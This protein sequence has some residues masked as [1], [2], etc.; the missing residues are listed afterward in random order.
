[1]F[2]SGVDADDEI[3]ETLERGADDFLSKPFN[4]SRLVAKVRAT[5]RLAER[6]HDA[7]SGAVG[8]GGALPLLKFCEDS[9]LS[10]RLTVRSGEE[11]RWADFMGGELAVA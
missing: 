10:G 2:L 1:V 11:T 7:L 3:V 6:R 4:V 9:R 5:L 8:P